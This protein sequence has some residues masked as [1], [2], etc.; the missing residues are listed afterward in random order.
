M[1]A[2]GVVLA[3]FVVAP[4]FHHGIL[5]GLTALVLV[6]GGVLWFCGR[7][8]RSAKIWTCRALMIR[9]SCGAL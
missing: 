9:A 6:M 8:P 3:K 2:S 5:R 4:A 7:S 1:G